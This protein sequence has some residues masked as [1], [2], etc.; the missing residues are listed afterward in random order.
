MSPYIYSPFNTVLSVLRQLGASIEPVSLPST[1][2]GLSAYYV[3][4]SA[5][6]YSNLARYDGIRYGTVPF[7]TSGVAS[8][9]TSFTPSRP[10]FTGTRSSP[11]EGTTI[12]D[13]ADVYAL[14]RSHALGAEVKRRI[15]LG[16]YALTAGLVCILQLATFCRGLTVLYSIVPHSAFDN[17]FLQAQRVRNL[18]RADFDR[19]FRISNVLAGSSAS[20]EAR[21]A[22]DVILHPSAIRT[23]P[24]LMPKSASASEGLQVYVQDVLTVPASLAGIPA[25]TV[26]MGYAEDDRWPVGVSVVG[27]WGSEELVMNVGEAIEH[28]LR[29]QNELK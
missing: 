16:S 14:T 28:N 7:T 13:T 4:A 18:V 21:G 22:V 26:P 1:R 2:Y 11:E 17:Y 6:A 5:E 9:R 25:L 10:Y 3:I 24:S 12:L 20:T 8:T 29:I 23:A 15:L 19:V 27:Q